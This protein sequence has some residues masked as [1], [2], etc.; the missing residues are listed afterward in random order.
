MKKYVA[1]LFQVLLLLMVAAPAAF[2]DLA[3]YPP[4]R[5]PAQNDDDACAAYPLDATN[6]M[7]IFTA[8][9]VVLAVV[10]TSG[11]AYRALRKTKEEG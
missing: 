4:E 5:Y 8:L 7:N 3:D 11:L 2:A 6:Q 1:I 10:G 9:I